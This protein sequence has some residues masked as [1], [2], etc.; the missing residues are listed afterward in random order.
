MK[1]KDF[2]LQLDEATDN[3]SDAHLICYIRFLADNI[4]VEELLFCKSITESAKS[5]DLFEIFDKLFQL[6]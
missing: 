1:G 5:Q 2:G 4:T 6:Q 3:N